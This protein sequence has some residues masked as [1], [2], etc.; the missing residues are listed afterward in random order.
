MQ[1]QGGKEAPK[2]LGEYLL[3]VIAAAR[4]M[5]ALH[6]VLS[7]LPDEVQVLPSALEDV[8]HSGTRLPKIFAYVMPT[9]DL[10][11]FAQQF[12]GE[13]LRQL[14]ALLAGHTAASVGP[15]EISSVCHMYQIPDDAVAL[16]RL[17]KSYPAPRSGDRGNKPAHQAHSGLS[18]ATEA[19]PPPGA[20]AT[21]SPMPTAPEGPLTLEVLEQI[22]ALVDRI[23][24]APF[25]DHQPIYQRN[26]DG[27][28]V[29]YTEYFF[30]I[31]S[32]RHSYFPKVDLEANESLFVEFTRNLDDLM[33]IQLL[34][35]RKWRQQRIGLNLAIGTVNSPTFKRFSTH[36]SDAER[37][38][39][40][41]ELHWIEAL[42]DIQD[43]GYAV[44]QLMNAGY[45]VAMDRITLAVLPYLN[46]AETKFRYLKLRF[47][48]D[49][50]A[51]IQPDAVLALRHC[52]PEKVVLTACDDRRALA[53]GD[54][55]KIA[56]YQGRL[57]DQMLSK[58]A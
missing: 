30:D 27:W 43:G 2:K 51:S 50:V 7:D 4:D 3:N 11:L 24:I 1:V 29:N 46:V 52:P 9:G 45:G 36:L 21:T 8:L 23:D 12:T 47:D 54:K 31:E 55:L 42:Q 10:F 17:V 18:A 15:D 41:C 6:V 58:A 22:N 35:E 5:Q 20:K 13:T 44:W 53:L 32:L 33:L 57:I 38:N 39:I 25:I 28:S 37:R 48:R 14:M 56:N 26:G 19:T 49:A 16:R 40:I 34:S